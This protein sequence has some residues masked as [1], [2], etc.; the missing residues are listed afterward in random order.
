MKRLFLLLVLLI[1]IASS[2]AA[3]DLM[4]TPVRLS[5]PLQVKTVGAASEYLM[6][7][8]DYKLKVLPPASPEA[9]QIARTGISPLAR[10]GAVVPLEE[11][12]LLLVG[13]NNRVV[14]DHEHKLYTFEAIPADQKGETDE[15]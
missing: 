9:L 12:L 10:T 13:N 4:R 14:I 11:A 1:G 3:Y 7:P 8:L 6:A 5:Y 2:A 15:K